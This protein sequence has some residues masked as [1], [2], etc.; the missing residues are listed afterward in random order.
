MVVDQD[1]DLESKD[2]AMDSM[3]HQSSLLNNEEDGEV[4]ENGEAMVPSVSKARRGAK[5]TKGDDEDRAIGGG[6]DS[7]SLRRYQTEEDANDSNV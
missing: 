5:F 6:H 3:L 2:A 4:D 7:K 1:Q